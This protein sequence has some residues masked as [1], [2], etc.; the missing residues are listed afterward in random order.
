MKNIAT[1]FH[2]MQ[3]CRILMDVTGATN[4]NDDS[5]RENLDLSLSWRK[6]IAIGHLNQNRMRICNRNRESALK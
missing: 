3:V 2:V 5:E 1:T 6:Q 4:M